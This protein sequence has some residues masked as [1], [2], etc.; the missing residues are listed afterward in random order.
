MIHR[1]WLRVKAIVHKKKIVQ[2]IQQKIVLF[3][4]EPS[5]KCLS[6]SIHIIGRFYLRMKQI[7]IEE[8][9]YIREIGSWIPWTTQFIDPV[10]VR[11]IQIFSGSIENLLP[12]CTCLCTGRSILFPKF[13]KLVL[14]ECR[15]FL[16]CHINYD[17]I[18]RFCAKNQRPGGSKSRNQHCLLC[19][20]HSLWN[21]LNFYDF[22]NGSRPSCFCFEKSCL[23]TWTYQRI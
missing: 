2:V 22:W 7:M 16:C 14:L 5:K 15:L 10:P 3:Y 9:W 20:I 18:W 4:S 21:L 12:T 19:I 11:N 23:K 8:K 17:W 1:L 6:M 13:W